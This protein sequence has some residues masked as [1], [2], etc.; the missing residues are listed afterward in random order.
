MKEYFFWMDS[1]IIRYIPQPAQRILAQHYIEKNNGK[2]VYYSAE[3][4]IATPKQ[5]GLREKLTRTKEINGFIFFTIKQFGYQEE[6]DFILM[7]NMLNK[8]LEL[9]F[10]RE[11]YSIL[12]LK[13][14]EEKFNW[15][16]LYFYSNKSSNL[17]LFK[18]K[19]SI[20]KSIPDTTVSY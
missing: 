17:R 4:L 10:A 12:N 2:I 3:E 1:N 20:L 8:G 9:H 16:Y 13:E 6:F 18:Q 7:K 15:L 11:E 5:L 14:L 19:Y